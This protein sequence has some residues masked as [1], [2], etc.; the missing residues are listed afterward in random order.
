MPADGTVGGA[1]TTAR[2]CSTAAPWATSG[3]LMLLTLIAMLAWE[4]GGT[5]L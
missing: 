2:F 3:E 1:E 5:K 4:L